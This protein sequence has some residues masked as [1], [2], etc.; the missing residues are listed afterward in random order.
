[1]ALPLLRGW[2]STFRLQWQWGS[3]P[4]FF[5]LMALSALLCS[6]L[7]T[8]SRV[9]IPDPSKPP[10]KSQNVGEQNAQ[11]PPIFSTV[12]SNSGTFSMWSPVSLVEQSYSYP[13]CLSAHGFA[14]L[15]GSVGTTTSVWHSGNSGW[16]P[17]SGKFLVGIMWW[18]GEVIDSYSAVLLMP[19]SSSMLLCGFWWRIEKEAWAC[20]FF[21]KQ[22]SARRW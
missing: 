21:S 19:H 2:T 16:S 22:C 17:C 12:E 15:C 3:S 1:M 7:L 18:H 14:F 20:G 13:D 11:L 8:L 4:F 10:I 5:L 9:K 6:A